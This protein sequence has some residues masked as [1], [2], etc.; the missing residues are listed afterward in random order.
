MKR[1]LFLSAIAV[2]SIIS[3]LGCDDENKIQ[4]E[5]ND[6]PVS[7]DSI[8]EAVSFAYVDLGL[9]VYW[10]TFN[11]GA[12]KP[13]EYGDYYAWGET[14]TKTDYSWETYK[15]CNGS[16]NTL[17]KYCN[18]SEYGYNGYTDD[19]YV[20]DPEDDVVQVKWGGNWRMPTREEMEEL[21]NSCSWTWD[22]IDSIEGFKVIGPSGNSIFLPDAGYYSGTEWIKSES[23]E[24]NRDGDLWSSTPG[25]DYKSY[26]VYFLTGRPY[27]GVTQ[28][29]R[30]RG[31]SVRPVCPS[32]RWL[33]DVSVTL[34][35]DSI[36]IILGNSYSLTATVKHNDDVL[37]RR[38]VW[39]SAD[40]TIATV[41]STGLVKGL[42]AGSTTITAS[43]ESKTVS[44]TITVID[45]SEIEHEYVDLGLSI[46]WAT[47]NV[48]ALSPEEYG[49]YYA[50]GETENK[51]DY[52]W[53][54]YKW[55]NGSETGL[56]KYNTDSNYGIVDNKTILDIEDDVAHV[57]WG[58]N[59][60]MPTKE[61]QD[62]LREKCTWTWTTLNDVYGY[63]V[64]SN[65]NGFTDRSIFLPAAGIF[66]GMSLNST[67]SCGDYRSSSLSNPLSA[68][69]IGFYCDFLLDAYENSRCDG[70]SVRPVCQ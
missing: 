24:D 39:A 34:D 69:H 35:S 6:K 9:S 54:T 61:E 17:T 19:K 23:F 21:M 58:G 3:L 49:G 13:E 5:K 45:E 57:K 36:L 16:E 30:Y 20:L 37:D 53:S 32:E 12:T 65:I 46:K 10:A 68:W 63:I 51:S 55:C 64:T 40:T 67:E 50:W 25:D 41:S 28:Y 59:W 7:T 56:T 62:E 2:V 47:V 66:F 29:D 33:N 27:K 70:R 18:N 4:N 44:C 43:L 15:W 52:S 8:P 42:S 11:V 26:F 31:W 48:G 14:E 22:C 38:V 1:I 60:R